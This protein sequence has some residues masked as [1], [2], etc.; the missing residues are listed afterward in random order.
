ML[1]KRRKTRINIDDV[2]RLMPAPDFPTGANLIDDGGVREAY[3]TGKGVFRIRAKA[4]VGQIS[5]RRKGITVR[6]LP[7]QV[8]PE[9]IVEQIN[10][11]LSDEKLE[12]V[13]KVTNL[14]DR[15]EGLRIVVECKTG[16]NPETILQ[17]L[18]T[19]TSLESSFSSN[20][21]VLVNGRPETLGIVDL[22]QHFVDHRLEVVV[23]RS[24]FRLEKAQDRLHIVEGLLIALKNIDLVVK[25]IRA[26]KDTAEARTKLQKALKLSE[27]QAN[28]ILEMPLRRLT[29]L[30]IGKI[31]DEATQLKTTIAE[32]QKL[33]ADEDL[34]K[35][36]VRDEFI[37]LRKEVAYPRK[38]EIINSSDL[39]KLS[40]ADSGA[41]D[42]FAEDVPCVVTLSTSGLIGM[43]ALQSKPKTGR[44]DLLVKEIKTTSQDTVGI[45]TNKGRVLRVTVND[46]PHM[47][48][49][50][51]G[52]EARV[53]FDM[54]PGETVVGCVS[55]NDSRPLMLVTTRGIA[56]RV[57]Q[58]EISKTKNGVSLISLKSGDTVI[59]A[60]QLDEHDDFLIITSDA[61]VIR[62]EASQVPLQGRSAAGV[63]G[64][65]IKEDATVTA[66][67]SLEGSQLAVASQNGLVKVTL[68]TE[69]PL[70][71]RGGSGVRLAKLNEN[72]S[73]ASAHTGET[74]DLY[75]ITKTGSLVAL[76]EPT[77]RDNKLLSLKEPIQ[78]VGHKRGMR[79]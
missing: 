45:I 50:S 78:V 15:K 52:L 3:L 47:D 23:R 68:L 37:L 22:L 21:V 4:E 5:A 40:I 62:P 76:G 41:S 19:L 18:Y 55:Q 56:K 67:L 53:V 13:N 42:V 63:T 27:V 46:L 2:L 48:E 20:N 38:T 8:G 60:F 73:V 59:S 61:Q 7:Y 10:N 66:A 26:S 74:V 31:K 1:D 79:S 28:H 25:T 70:K 16:V 54:E 69:I 34:Q 17:K 30:E 77:R 24:Q 36:T 72:D 32:L 29:S 51:R 11:L 58:E 39:P 57:T 6:E 12:G 33:L 35:T 49:R 71:K 75:G 65:R 64:M 14:S 44:H 43:G 9:Q